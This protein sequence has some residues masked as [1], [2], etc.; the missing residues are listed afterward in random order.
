M[1]F[2]EHIQQL[3]I[4]Q[5]LRNRLALYWQSE[6][7][8][9]H[10]LNV[11]ELVPACSWHWPLV[12]STAF[13]GESSRHF[14]FWFSLVL[15]RAMVDLLD[16]DDYPSDALV[17]LLT[18][19]ES[20]RQRLKS[21]DWRFR[22]DLICCYLEHFFSPK[23]NS[24]D[25]YFYWQQRLTCLRQD[26]SFLMQSIEHVKQRQEF[27]LAQCWHY[28]K[29]QLPECNKNPDALL[30]ALQRFCEGLYYY[31]FQR[32]IN[33]DM[34][35]LPSLVEK[36][37]QDWGGLWIDEQSAR[38]FTRIYHGF[39]SLRASL[40]SNLRPSLAQFADMAAVLMAQV[41]IVGS[42]LPDPMAW[43]FAPVS[44]HPAVAE[45]LKK[46][47][48]YRAWPNEDY[49]GAWSL[50]IED[51]LK[52]SNQLD[53]FLN[54]QWLRIGVRYHPERCLGLAKW[55][56]NAMTRLFELENITII[57]MDPSEKMFA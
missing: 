36:W 19:H 55:A 27:E 30:I 15:E 29:M 48:H 28:L 54:L 13:A 52:Q 40:K 24:G 9:G 17:H 57:R 14:D 26:P 10:G 11:F 20:E 3:S 2:Y 56:N 33:G 32:R 7:W 31:F 6:S 34:D 25:V 1:L 5:V 50:A 23:K 8:F 37:A 4:K 44:P 41:F 42:E 53:Y 39:L 22:R 51:V 45:F 43:L 35:M 46:Q 47:K 21:A 16:A 18:N 38:C 12:M 49:P